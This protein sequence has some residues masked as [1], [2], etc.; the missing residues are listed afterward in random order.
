MPD[1]LKQFYNATI[2]APAFA[3]GATV[4]LFTNGA[5]TR[6]VIKDIAVNNNTFPSPPNLT[7]AGTRT[8]SLGANVS[9][10]EIVDV[11][12]AVGVSFTPSLVFSS[13]SL[14]YSEGGT[15]QLSTT[16]NINGTQVSGAPAVAQMYAGSEAGVTFNTVTY[17]APDGDVFS[18]LSNGIDIWFLTKNAGDSVGTR[19]TVNTGNTNTFSCIAF[20]GINTFYWLSSP[21]NLRIF[22][23]DTETT[24]NITMTSFGVAAGF[25]RLVHSNG[26]LLYVSSSSNYMNIIEISTGRW[27][28]FSGSGSVG[29]WDLAGGIPGFW[30]E[31][32]T[33]VATVLW[34]RQSGTA[35][36]IRAVSAPIPALT[37]ASASNVTAWTLTTLTA[38]GFGGYSAATTNNHV[39]LSSADGG[40]MLNSSDWPAILSGLSGPAGGGWLLT[41]I[42]TTNSSFRRPR[43]STSF[44]PT[45]NT[46][47]FPNTISLRVTGVEV[48]P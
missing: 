43:R 28:Q 4:P 14:A 12:Q 10:S 21:S 36:Y 5:T 42:N 40:V 46:T 30:F 2:N 9:G 44:S 45:V 38:A 8:A 29:T 48:T 24:T 33:R 34:Y 47:N 16:F 39:A 11:S 3:G 25:A 6:A 23:A 32:S 13:T 26:Y 31:P 35:Q 7:V 41:L 17:Y 22:N 1:T 37:A 19:T 18:V 27:I 20:D 15:Q